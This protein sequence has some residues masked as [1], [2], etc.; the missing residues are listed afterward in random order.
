[1]TTI[2][3]IEDVLDQFTVF[4][5]REQVAEALLNKFEIRLKSEDVESTVQQRTSQLIE[6]LLNAQVSNVDPGDHETILS[7][8]RFLIAEA[9][10]GSHDLGQPTPGP[11]Q[12]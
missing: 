10:G 4:S 12:R 9:I 3:D 11:V 7:R 6:G 5:T 2:K 1:M 8:W